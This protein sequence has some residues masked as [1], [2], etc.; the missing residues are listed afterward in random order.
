MKINELSNELSVTNKELI[1]FLKE[2]NFKVSSH[3][4]TASDEM[5][6]LAREHFNNKPV[7]IKEIEKAEEVESVIS[8]KPETYVPKVFN[9]EDKITCRSVTPWKLIEVGVDKNTIYSWSGYGDI[10]YVAY[11]DLQSMRKKDILRKSKIIIEDADLC[12]QWSRDLGETYKY[13][14][15]VEYPEEFFDLTDEKF[16]GLLTKAPDVV[17]E[18]IKYTALN[19]VRNENYPTVQKLN[20]VDEILGTCIKD[21]L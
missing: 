5:I 16:R 18:V 12:Y 10:D 13:F 3:M 20:I 2:N 8:K 17:K 6:D 19:M 15:D 21:F 9:P 1:T 4:Q 14:L 7:K 11:K